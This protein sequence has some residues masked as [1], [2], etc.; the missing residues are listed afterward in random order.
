MKRIK[1]VA[2]AAV[3][4]VIAL[5]CM[6]LAVDVVSPQP[7][8]QASRSDLR[9]ERAEPLGDLCGERE[10]S[11]RHLLLPTAPVVPMF[12]SR[13]GSA[14]ADVDGAGDDTMTAV[15]AASLAAR[16]VVPL[17]RSGQ[18]PVVLQVFRC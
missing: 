14:A 1:G 10:R 15:T 11:S 7:A 9:I 3:V 13:S 17:S 12:E 18:L 2:R 5:L 6:L 8:P 16:H 4:G